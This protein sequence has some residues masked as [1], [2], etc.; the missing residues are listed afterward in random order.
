MEKKLRGLFDYQRFENNS[1]LAKLISETE[2]RYNVS[3][4]RRNSAML[5]DDDLAFVA[6]AGTPDEIK[7]KKESENK[8][9]EK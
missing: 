1:R 6:A 4:A 3:G 9:W 7:G 2:E 5:S 8:L